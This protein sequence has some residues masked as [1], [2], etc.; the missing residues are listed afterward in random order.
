MFEEKCDK[1]LF[2]QSIFS[3]LFI[4]SRQQIMNSL[5]FLPSSFIIHFH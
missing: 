3:N 2:R 4:S 5:Y 1:A